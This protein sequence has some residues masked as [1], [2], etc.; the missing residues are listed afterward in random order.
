MASS[1]NL[2][3]TDMISQ[4]FEDSLYM[5]F[6][7]ARKLRHEFVTVEHLLLAIFGEKDS[8]AVYDH[9]QKPCYAGL[10]Q[11]VGEI[12]LAKILLL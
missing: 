3:E 11:L 9:Q 8:H 5:A 4:E 1:L 7:E 2:K 10:F 6:V 12:K